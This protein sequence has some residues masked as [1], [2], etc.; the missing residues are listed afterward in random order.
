[1]MG[2]FKDGITEISKPLNLEGDRDPEA[3]QKFK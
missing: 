1:M 2:Y 3:L